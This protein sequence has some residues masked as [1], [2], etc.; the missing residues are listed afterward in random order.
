[1]N[2]VI[3]IVLIII[4]F[5]LLN[6][7]GVKFVG[8]LRRAK[9]FK[10]VLSRIK[11][12]IPDGYTLY[13]SSAEDL[14]ISLRKEKPLTVLAMNFRPVRISNKD[15]QGLSDED[16]PELAREICLMLG[17]NFDNMRSVQSTGFDKWEIKEYNDKQNYY[18]LYIAKME[19]Q[20]I[21]PILATSNGNKKSGINDMEELVNS[22]EVTE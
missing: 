14:L 11:Y 5:I 6:T 20:W 15:V 9:Y 8:K 18:R 17:F 19:G 4:G 3:I 13:A 10:E 21:F 12:K 1:M 22:I 2:T 7:V 16:F